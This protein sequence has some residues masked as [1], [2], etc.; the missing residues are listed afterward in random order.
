VTN[1]LRLLTLPLFYNMINEA[2]E[3]TGTLHDYCMD[4]TDV[5]GTLEQFNTFVNAALLL[6]TASIFANYATQPALLAANLAVVPLLLGL[7]APLYL[8]YQQ[9]LAMG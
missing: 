9:C 6:I 7:V 4:Y 3:L 1:P 5:C 8:L 2:I